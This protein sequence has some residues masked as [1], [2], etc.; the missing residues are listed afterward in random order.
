MT[1]RFGKIFLLIISLSLISSASDIFPLTLI[2]KTQLMV[3]FIGPKGKKLI[4]KSDFNQSLQGIH[5]IDFRYENSLIAVAYV[6]GEI[7]FHQKNKKW[8][9]TQLSENEW[10]IEKKS[11]KMD[12]TKCT[13]R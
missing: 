12:I 6:T 2:C 4:K 5:T 11:E 3:E 13:I 10:I 1:L 7:T 9:V 8:I